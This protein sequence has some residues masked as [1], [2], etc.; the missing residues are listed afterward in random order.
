LELPTLK[1]TPY[2]GAAK[3]KQFLPIDSVRHRSLLD[4]G[5]A[6]NKHTNAHQQ[7]IVE[8]LVICL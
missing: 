2:C 8:N 5:Q 3:K 7:K 6:A 1:S 4:V